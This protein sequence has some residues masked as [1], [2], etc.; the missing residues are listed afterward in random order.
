MRMV[1]VESAVA[2][3][4]LPTRRLEFLGEQFAVLRWRHGRVLSTIEKQNRNSRL[5]EP[6]SHVNRHPGIGGPVAVCGRHVRPGPDSRRILGRRA[7]DLGEA[8][9]VHERRVEVNLSDALGECGG[10]ARREETAPAHPHEAC[11]WREADLLD[12]KLLKRAAYAKPFFVHSVLECF[13]C[14]MVP[15]LRKKIQDAGPVHVRLGP[16]HRPGPGQTR[17]RI[18]FRRHNPGL[19]PLEVEYSPIVSIPCVVAKR[20]LR[21][22]NLFGNAFMGFIRRALLPGRHPLRRIGLA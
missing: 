7:A 5:R 10:I 11:L 9:E 6:I 15:P 21:G 12:K 22:G 20:L 8:I 14:Y 13:D 3:V 17:G 19:A 2:D 16:L 1:A 4:D 18:A